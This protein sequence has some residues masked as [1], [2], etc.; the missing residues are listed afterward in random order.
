MDE[1]KRFCC[2]WRTQEQVLCLNNLIKS[3]F[4]S[5]Y[6]NESL[7]FHLIILLK[8]CFLFPFRTT[9]WLFSFKYLIDFIIDQNIIIDKENSQTN[10]ACW[11]N[12]DLLD[13]VS[14]L[15]SFLMTVYDL[16]YTQVSKS[17]TLRS[18]M[19]FVRRIYTSE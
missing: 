3:Y 17:Y 8:C 9:F 12:P 16:V 19:G 13:F 14:R 6:K 15:V 1:G 5:F 18:I 7:P 10:I 11:M 4:S 2:C